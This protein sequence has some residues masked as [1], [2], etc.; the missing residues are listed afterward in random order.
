MKNNAYQWV[1]F[2]EALADKLLA[3]SDKRDELFELM[4]KV[5]AEQPLMKYLN[6]ER[7]DWWGPRNHHMDP[8]TVIS[9]L[10]RGTTD[11]NRIKLAKVLVETF[12]V[13]LPAPVQFAGIPVLNNMNSFFN[14]PVE[15]WEL[16]VQAME[17]AKT[18]NFSDS[19]KTAFEKAI[20]VK[21]NGLAYITMGLYWIRPNIFVPLDGN[22]RAFAS[23]HYDITAPSGNCTGEEYVC[24][25][26]E[27]S[28]G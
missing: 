5:R 16:F 8:L 11:T 6:F 22:S 14:G 3:Y 12:E 21:G 13:G 26:L 7:E 27:N 1:S 2:Y 9:I 24:F 28:Q 10:N 20:A 25:F 23:A 19:F 4:K 17:S 15:I 18:S